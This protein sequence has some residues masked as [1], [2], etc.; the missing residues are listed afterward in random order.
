M[1]EDD[2]GRILRAAREVLDQPQPLP[3][4]IGINRGH[5][6][7]GDI[8]TSFR[9]TFTVMGDTVNLAAR[10]MAAAKPGE[11]YA[12]GTVL[13]R[14][15]T[16]FNS[17]A[18]EPFYV[19]GKSEPVQAY[20]V[21][22]ATGTKSDTFGTLPFRGRDKELSLL[23]EVFGAAEAGRGGTILVEAE[24]GAGKTRLVTE[25][26]VAASSAELVFFQ[27]EPQTTGVP[28]HALRTAMRSLLDVD[29]VDRVE[30]GR[31]ML[32]SIGRLNQD[33]LPFAPLLA[34]ILDADVDT[35]PETQAIA[36]QFLRQRVADLLVSTL[37]AAVPG[38]MILIADDAHWFDDT[39]S[40]IVAHLAR[41]GRNRPWL[42]CVTRRPHSQGG[43]TPTDPDT[44]LELDLLTDDV[45][46]ELVEA[47]TEKLPLRPHE[48]D[49]VVAR[50]GGTPLF[51]EELLRIVRDTDMESLPDTLDAVAMREIDALP[52]GPRRVLRLASVLGRSFERSLLVQLLKIESVDTGLDPLEELGAQLLPDPSGE[53]AVR[54]RHA[55]LQE[56]AYQSL[57]FRQRLLL[58]QKAGEAIE[59]GGTETGDVAALL[60]YHFLAAQDWERTWRY[61]RDAARIARDAH[62][63]AE[64]VV[65]LERAVAASRR[66]GEVSSGELFDVLGE[67]G[68]SL[69]LL[70]EYERAD[71][72]YRRAGTCQADSI[73]RG[74]MAYRRAYLRS[75]YLGRPG[76]AI[77]LV[78]SARAA[79]ESADEEAAGLHALLLAEE[80]DARQRQ[81]RLSEAIECAGRAAE[82]A[83]RSNQKRALAIALRVRNTS[84][85]KAGRL[86][87]ADS[88]DQV[89]ELFEELGDEVRVA[90][91]LGNIA[92][93]AFYSSQWDRAAHYL[94]LCAEASTKAGDLAT[95]AL[96][97]GNLGELRTDQGRLEEAVALLAPSRRTL[98]S[99]GFPVATAGTTT[100][101]GRAVA[102]LGDI[103]GGLALLRSAV[104]TC[105]EIGAHYEALEAYIRLA[106]ILVFDGRLAEARPALQ[107]ARDLER[108][109]GN[110][111]LATLLERVELTLVASDEGVSPAS[112]ESFLERARRDGATYE[113]LVVLA[114]A[115]RSGVPVEHE[116][117]SR[118]AQALDV[119]RLPMFVRN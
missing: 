59:R 11:I 3:V 46:H 44:R 91:T 111:P 99:F 52:E 72:A 12:T 117:I 10:L 50:A 60:S 101:L 82:E 56:A 20:G 2:E 19:K 75:E 24:R 94:T 35:T 83:E 67:L 79:L 13:D 95:A 14:A 55:L 107:R 66:L 116:H 15:R 38:P 109:V 5:V 25:F 88:M 47:A 33:L 102:F 103:D 51:L 110:T 97:N 106:E 32:K 61:A 8:G 104:A 18:I 39:S 115:E 53:G 86:E 89:L 76:A 70:G 69:E 36:E 23:K 81:G 49:A 71:D 40:E 92:L 84:F 113:E 37:D 87:E 108:S 1:Q 118:L 43:F 31:Q 64:T 7:A 9:R 78:R 112:L 119:V 77:R 65:H 114:L 17:E 62:A 96:T 6:F 85:G 58:H 16:V 68:F 45:S 41:A 21:G 74:Q 42:L 80:A 48:R 93:I 29:A 28:Y 98:E 63:L 22:V 34:P 100:Q 105:D 26:A 30:A 90:L 57:P 54:F 73:Q 4:R 27:G